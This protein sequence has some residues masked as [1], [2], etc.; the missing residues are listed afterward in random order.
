MARRRQGHERLR[1]WRER[2]KITQVEAAARLGIDFVT[3]SK[4]E[5]GK[6]RPGLE[7]AVRIADATDGEVPVESW[8]VAEAKAS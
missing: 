2:L 6:L 4:F 8:V 5:R 1:A 3:L 7:R